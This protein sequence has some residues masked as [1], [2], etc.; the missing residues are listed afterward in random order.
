MSMTENSREDQI[1]RR[2]LALWTEAG[3]RGVVN[4]Y[5]DAAARQID[6]EYEA[7]DDAG[8]RQRTPLIP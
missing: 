5:W 1:R 3:Q 8:D 2:A 4:D 6:E 7:A